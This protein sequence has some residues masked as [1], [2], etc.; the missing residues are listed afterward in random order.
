MSIPEPRQ[1]IMAKPAGK[2]DSQQTTVLIEQT[3]L[4]DSIASFPGA[5][6]LSSRAPRWQPASSGEK[7]A[8]FSHG[9][10]VFYQ[11]P[12]IRSRIDTSVPFSAVAAHVG[13]VA[14]DTIVTTAARLIITFA[15]PDKTHKAGVSVS[16]DTAFY[17][18][19]HEGD[20]RRAT[21]ALSRTTVRVP[22]RL[23]L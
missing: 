3:L 16:I 23:L 18:A 11:I 13:I 15:K 8:E 2:C 9:P 5:S 17:E 19:C 10:F 7:R 14:T 21:F 4:R 1:G 22:G 12:C 6:G 20:D